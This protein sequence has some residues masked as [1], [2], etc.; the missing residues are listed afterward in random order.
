[1]KKTG[2]LLIALAILAGVGFA[3]LNR[4][5]V[6]KEGST[7]YRL[8]RWTGNVI[9][10]IPP[11]P[12]SSPVIPAK[13]RNP[14]EAEWTADFIRSLVRMPDPPPAPVADWQDAG[15]EELAKCEVGK[16]ETA[17]IP[18]GGIMARFYNGNEQGVMVGLFYVTIDGKTKELQ[19]VPNVIL[20]QREEVVI[21]FPVGDM[22]NEADLKAAQKDFRL[23]TKVRDKTFSVKLSRAKIFRLP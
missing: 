19:L 13:P 20:R 4:W 8:D 12:P 10:L 22:R 1:M 7:A 6:V 18:P 15:P 14:V 17:G 9:R 3:W 2:Y 23:W 21:H 11:D 5:Q 16:V